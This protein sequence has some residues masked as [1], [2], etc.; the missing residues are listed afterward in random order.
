MGTGTGTGT[1]GRSLASQH[2]PPFSCEEVDC[3]RQRRP[4][5][6]TQQQ[7]IVYRPL[8]RAHSWRR[9]G[10]FWST[11]SSLSCGW[12]HL[13]GTPGA[14]MSIC[15]ADRL[16]GT[17]AAQ[18]HEVMQ[19]WAQVPGPRSLKWMSVENCSGW[20]RKFVCTAACVI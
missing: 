2:F 11:D 14:R 9:A 15:T 16:P 6:F 1:G 17:G 19:M 5:A 18:Q 13:L 12:R 7:V 4:S 10:A 3:Q 20:R 8:S